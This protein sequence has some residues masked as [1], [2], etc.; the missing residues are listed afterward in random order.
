MLVV[1]ILERVTG[2]A[3]ARILNEFVNEPLALRRTSVLA[4][5]DDLMACIP[6]FG[7]EVTTDGRIADVRG[8]YH[9]GWCAPRLVAS[10]AEEITRLFDALTAGQLLA[11][12]TLSQMITLVPLPGSQ[13]PPMVLS[14]GMVLYSNGASR[15]GRNYHHGGGGP[16]YDLSATI[17]PDTRIGRVGV[18]VFANISSGPRADDVEEALLALVFDATA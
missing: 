14:V 7:S 2:R 16:G 4:E 8:R 9:P 15:Y 12:K 5:M 3:F 6:G 1:D 13:E 17:Y 11:T 10:T 18:A